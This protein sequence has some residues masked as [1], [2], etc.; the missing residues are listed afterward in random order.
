MS[1][2]LLKLYKFGV[3]T[4]LVYQ[5]H[6]DLY[7]DPDLEYGDIKSSINN[8]LS[9]N[10]IFPTKIENNYFFIITLDFKIIKINLNDKD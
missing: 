9:K 5:S 7:S 1:E 3:F 10:L 4:L 8:V 6:V 2:N